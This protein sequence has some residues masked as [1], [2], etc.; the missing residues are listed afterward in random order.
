[1]H[2]RNLAD[3]YLPLIDPETQVLPKGIFPRCPNCGGQAF[4]NVR[5]G[6]WFV[7]EP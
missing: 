3:Q 4:P 6:G 7:D 2:A 5:G 1:M